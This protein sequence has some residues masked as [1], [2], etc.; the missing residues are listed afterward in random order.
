MS[1]LDE[2]LRQ[3]IL[4][5]VD[6]SFDAQIAF[7]RDLVARPSIRG[8]EH[9]AQDLMFQ[10]MRSRGLAMDRWRVN[11]DDIKHHEG[12]SPIAVDYANAWNVVGTH[13]P[14]AESGR[15]LILNG[16]VDVVPVGPLDMWSS[17][18]FDPRID[19][20]WMY[21]RGAGDMKAGVVA[22]MF[23]LD[24]LRAAGVQPAGT[25]HLE[26]VCEEESTGNGA[27]ATLLRGYTADAALISEPTGLHLTRAVMGVL[28][29]KVKVRGYPVH[30]SRAGTGS[31]AIMAAYD[32]VAS[33]REIEA[34][35]NGIKGETKHYGELGHPVN[36][37]IGKIQGG[38]WASSV[39]AWCEM[40]CRI[41]I[42]PGHKPQAMAREI[43]GAIRTASSAHP[44]LSNNPP[45]VE[46][47]GFFTE[48]Y[49]LE[50][51]SDAEQTLATQHQAV[52]GA[53]LGDQPTT[54]YVDSRVY[55]LYGNMPT[56][57]YGPEAENVHGFD[58]RV[59]ISSI[60]EA[61][62]TIALFVA[63]WCGVEPVGEA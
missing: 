58:E 38:D 41:S 2:N 14:N 24:A 57:V 3:R 52:T 55:V 23:A 62:K 7:T 29:F 5:A 25:V 6:S 59:R 19:G 16:H 61:T 50:P 40:D 60:R 27:L 28:W 33:L 30:V 44:F 43:E 17:P 34:R 51:G 1:G 47:N 11:A 12:F 18:P 49:D 20:D 39:P 10:A 31:N 56:L 48:G 22:N 46:F 21:G 4:D 9:L 45:E 32:L 42:Y 15:S 53:A 63:D 8:Q 37:N 36:L 54:A 35:W 13:R 26:S